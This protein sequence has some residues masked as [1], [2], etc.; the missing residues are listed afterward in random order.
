MPTQNSADSAIIF[1]LISNMKVL[2]E[3]EETTLGKQLLRSQLL[4]F[5]RLARAPDTD[6]LRSLTF[7][8]GT[9]QPA[10]SRYVRRGVGGNAPKGVLEDEYW[11]LSDNLHRAGVEK[12]GVESL[13]QLMCMHVLKIE[14]MS[15]R[16]ERDV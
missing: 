15:T 16:L 2:Q 4:L 7:I 8:E 11:T 10:T 14:G 5:G 12:S 3:A 6:P 9:T 1:F 13:R